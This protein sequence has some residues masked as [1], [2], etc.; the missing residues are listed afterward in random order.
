LIYRKRKVKYSTG[1]HGNTQPPIL[2]R[3]LPKSPIPLKIN[4]NKLNFCKE[5]H[6]SDHQFKAFVCK[7][8]SDIDVTNAMAI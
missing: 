3:F 2:C 5:S 4:N 6:V 1:A 8:A 7:C